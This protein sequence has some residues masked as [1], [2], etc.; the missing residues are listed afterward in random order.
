VLGGLDTVELAVI[1]AEARL[2]RMAGHGFW[3]F[4]DSLVRVE[5]LSAEL[6]L[7]DADDVEL[8]VRH[9]ERL[10][11]VAETGDGARA[12]IARVLARLPE[13]G[14]GREAGTGG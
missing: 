9:F 6:R 1:P 11:E 14:I 2:P 7:R 5:T 12:V 8:Y 13:S 3:I 10:W 4:D